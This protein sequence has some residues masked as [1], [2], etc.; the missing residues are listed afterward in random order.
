MLMENISIEQRVS[1]CLKNNKHIKF[2]EAYRFLTQVMPASPKEIFKHGEGIKRAKYFFDQLDNPQDAISPIHLAGTSG[3]GS[4]ANI[5]T[6][7]L[8]GHGASTGTHTSPHIYDIRERCMINGQLCSKD[9]FTNSF[10][11]ILP[12]VFDMTDTIYGRPT[13][14]E[15]TNAIAFTAFKDAQLDYA[16]IETGLGGQ[17]DSTNTISRTDKLSVITSLGLDH[18]E[19]LGNSLAEIA[20]QKA[21]IFIPNGEVVVLRPDS[22]EALEAI[23]NVATERNVSVVWA[24]PNWVK[25]HHSDLNGST[26]TYDDGVNRF[27]NLHLSLIGQHQLE[28]VAVGI[29]AFL[30]IAVRD[31][32]EVSR[33]LMNEALSNISMPARFEV[34]N[35]FGKKLILDGAHN[36]QKLEAFIATMEK[37]K[38]KCPIWVLALK[39]TKDTESIID[40]I[41]PV[42]EH[43]VVTQF[44]A[45]Q[46]GPAT[47]MKMQPEDIASVA[48]RSS[49][50]HVSVFED[51]LEALQFACSVSV[52][53]PVVVSGSFYLIGELHDRL[54]DLGI[55]G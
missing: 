26:F 51:N 48:R 18:T 29:C 40:V 28:N 55:N 4:T 16:V 36:S 20:T 10:E 5:I 11:S 22:Q 42:V 1:E 49:I 7:L 31:K 12:A 32:I 45:S 21:G 44:F 2:D 23:K 38:V 54:A 34:A 6:S 46:D 43:L 39:K 17:Y 35:A 25:L 15:A 27:E 30:K 33:D 3:K 19:I 14:F 8:L 52:D 9:I 53:D 24:E 47:H 13:Y 41:S 37:L 50:K